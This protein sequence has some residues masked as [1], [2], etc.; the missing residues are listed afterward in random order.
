MA[1]RRVGSVPIRSNPINRYIVLDTEGYDWYVPPPSFDAF[2]SY[3]INDTV[4]NG[5]SLLEAQ[6]ERERDRELERES[7]EDR[8]WADEG[9]CSTGY[10][11]PQEYLDDRD[12]D[13]DV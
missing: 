13:S 10:L 12:E 4:N 8:G 5:D 11:D 7:L 3:C 2:V 9:P 6:V 1:K